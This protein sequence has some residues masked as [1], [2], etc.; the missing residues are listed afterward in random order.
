MALFSKRTL[1]SLPTLPDLPELPPRDR[2]SPLMPFAVGLGMVVA[3]LLLRRTDPDLLRLPQ[4]AT[5]PHWRGL[6]RRRDMA[7]TARD[8]IAGLIPRNL[9]GSLGR[10][11]ILMGG[12]LV[13]VRA[14]DELVDDDSA[15]Y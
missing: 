6:T 8:G 5:K 13:L 3:G 4:P 1:P 2:L 7:R 10:T 11:L 12:A 14:L 9:T 15:N